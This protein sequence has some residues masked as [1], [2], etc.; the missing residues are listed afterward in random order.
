LIGTAVATFFT[1]SDF[2]LDDM[3]RVTWGNSWRGLELAFNFGRYETYINLSLGLAV[4]FLA[5]S[6]GLMYFLNS[7]DNDS[8]DK[9]IRKKLWYSALPFL[10][11]FL[12]FLVN[13]L[14]MKGYAV[15]PESGIVFMEKYKYLNNFLGMPIVLIIFLTGV[16]AV[17]FGL[18]VSLTKNSTKGIWSAGF[19]TILTVFAL[20]LVAG[21]NNT[22]FYPS[23]SN[24][25]SSLTIANAS[26]SK[27]TL[28]AMSYV[29]LFVPFVM[30]YIW[31]AWKVINKK[32]IDEEEMSDEESHAY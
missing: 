27:Y 28:T 32:K 10:V 1:G 15:D 2:R 12:F 30:A 18:I 13:I 17:L 4:F 25:Q 5:R 9:R 14:V 26:S 22:A 6:L 20:L 11:F 8:L 23:Y 7:I 24:L 3:N 21:F 31:Y 16:V 29:S 19:G